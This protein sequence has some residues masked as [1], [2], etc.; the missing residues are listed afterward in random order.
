MLPSMTP[1]E[2]LVAAFAD[3][4]W[5]DSY[6]KSIRRYWRVELWETPMGHTPRDAII[7]EH[8]VPMGYVRVYLRDDPLPSTD[9]FTDTAHALARIAASKKP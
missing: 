4:R 7:I 9:D 2:Q 1:Y 5:V 8:D 3:A 6:K